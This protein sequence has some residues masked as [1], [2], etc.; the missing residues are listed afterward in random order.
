MNTYS[1]VRDCSDLR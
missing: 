1:A